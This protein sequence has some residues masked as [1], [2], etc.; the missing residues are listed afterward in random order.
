MVLLFMTLMATASPVSLCLAYLTLR[1]A[2][3]QPRATTTHTNKHTDT[4]QTSTSVTPCPP[5]ARPPPPSTRTRGRMAATAVWRPTRRHHQHTSFAARPAPTPTAGTHVAR[6]PLS[7]RA[8]AALSAL[9]ATPA[10]HPPHPPPP[11]RSSANALAKL[12]NP[13]RVVE[14]VIP[15]RRRHVHAGERVGRRR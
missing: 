6:A 13:K 14:H 7:R 4:Q 9:P 5:A 1:R 12:A 10:V 11:P 8:A 3:D 2:T 15:H